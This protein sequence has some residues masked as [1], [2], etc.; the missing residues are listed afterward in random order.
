MVCG[1]AFKSVIKSEL[2]TLPMI[3]AQLMIG[4]LLMFVAE[5][6]YGRTR[7]D[8]GAKNSVPRTSGDAANPYV[9][10]VEPERVD[11]TDVAVTESEL[12]RLSPA[13]V[14]GV[15]CFQCLALMPGMSRSGSTI[16]GGL[17]LGI[18][19][20]TAARFSFLLS[21]PAITAAAVYSLWSD[22]IKPCAHRRRDRAVRLVRVDHP[23]GDRHRGVGDR[24]LW[25]NR[26][27]D[28]IS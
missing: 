22:A 15:G 26:A 7:R 24:R 9:S 2:R 10:P 5:W 13:Q 27:V 6:F 4:S 18:T 23:S 16:S 14:I 20:E 17:L 3:A 11:R 12:D 28:A 25:R 1:L 8:A 19:R 21:L